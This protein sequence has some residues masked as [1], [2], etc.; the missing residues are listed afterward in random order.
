LTNGKK[1]TATKNTTSSA[2]DQNDPKIVIEALL[3][4]ASSERGLDRQDTI[5]LVEAVERVMATRRGKLDSRGLCLNLSLSPASISGCA[6][7]LERLAANLIDNAISYNV[8]QGSPRRRPPP[9]PLVPK[10]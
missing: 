6:D 5:D 3:N 8:T 7:L 10:A 4:L 9:L 1:Q 2:I